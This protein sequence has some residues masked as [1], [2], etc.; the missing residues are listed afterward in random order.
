MIAQRPRIALVTPNL[1]VPHD[2]ARGRYIHATAIELSKLAEVR[3]F[4]PQVRYPRLPAAL[5]PRTFV[6]G[7]VA[8]DYRLPGIDLQAYSY[9]AVPGLSRVGN[10]VVGATALAPRLRAFMPD[11]VLAYWVYPDGDAAVRAARAIGVPCIVGGRGSDVHQRS[12]LLRWL[13]RRTLAKADSVLTVSQAMRRAVIDAYGIA[14]AR[15][16]C[17][18]NGID[19]AVFQPADRSS[20]R[21]ALGIRP[22]ARLVAYVGR[23]VEAKGLRELIEAFTALAAA[24]RQV[25]LVLVGHGVMQAELRALAAATGL[26]ERIHFP[27]GMEPPDVARWLAACN[28]LALPSWSEGYPNVLVEA[29]ASGRPVVASDVGGAAEIVDAGNGLLVPARDAP[30]F[31]AALAAALDREWDAAAMS[32]A[33]SR[34]WDQVAAETLAACRQ[35]LGAAAVGAVACTSVPE[36]GGG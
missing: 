17:I 24:D 11:L 6:H 9:P 1:P 2:L 4:L 22:D 14:P 5:G 32:R 15:V 10:G 19:T 34:G 36:T 3:V 27:G 16:G 18:V 25:E 30:A 8:D 12:G 23:M 21:A 31:A 26:G 35:V 20:A 33:M 28:V 29:I 13:T 7:L